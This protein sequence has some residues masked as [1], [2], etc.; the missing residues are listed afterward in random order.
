MS[1]RGT[2]GRVLREALNGGPAPASVRARTR[3]LTVSDRRIPY[4]GRIRISEVGE[5]RYIDF[6]RRLPASTST[7]T[8]SGSR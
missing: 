1:A 6:S 4:R 3:S 7:R 8:L 2:D 5:Q